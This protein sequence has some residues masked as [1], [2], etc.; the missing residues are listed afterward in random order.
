VLP[1]GTPS[2][3]SSQGGCNLAVSS[4]LEGPVGAMDI[5]RYSCISLPAYLPYAPQTNPCI[6]GGWPEHQVGHGM[7]YEHACIV[8]F[9]HFVKAIF[10][11]TPSL[12]PP[13]SFLHPSAFSAI[14]S[15]QGHELM[16]VHQHALGCMLQCACQ[17]SLPSSW[18][19]P[20]RCSVSSGAWIMPGYG[21]CLVAASCEHC[22]CTGI[23]PQYLQGMQPIPPLLSS[24]QQASLTFCLLTSSSYL[25]TQ[26]TMACWPPNPSMEI[27]SIRE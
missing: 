12:P 21:A 22:D 16:P 5:Y 18:M 10:P 13:F 17:P 1:V 26:C 11:F 19:Q 9:P 8:F 23:P 20:G 27:Q 3:L 6:Q 25:I 2:S 14:R 15:M 7:G 24:S 4:N